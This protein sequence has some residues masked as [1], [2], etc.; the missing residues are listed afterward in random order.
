MNSR[1]KFIRT[2]ALL[3]GAAYFYP[4][5]DLKSESLENT[6]SGDTEDYWNLVRAQ[7]P[8]KSNKTFLNNGTMGPSPYPVLQAVIEEMNEIEGSAR[9]GGNDSRAVQDLARLISC[10][11]DEISL[12]HNVTEGINIVAF[13]L[14]LQ[15][16]D[17]V[18][19]T[20]H[21]HVGNA[22]P[23]LSRAKQ[24]GIVV[25]AVQPGKDAAT[26]LQNILEAISKKTK[27]LAIPHMPCTIGQ[28]FP[29]QEICKLAREN[30]IYT[31]IDGAHPPGMM[32]V[33]VKAMGCDFYVSCVHKWLMGPKGTAF[34]Y[35]SDEKRE[36]LS[37]RFGGAGVDTGWDMLANPPAMEE[38]V[39]TGH[40]YYYG[41]QNAA[42]YLGISKAIEFHEQIGVVN[43]ENRV[44]FLSEYLR[45]KL[46]NLSAD[47]EILTPEEKKSRAAVT[48][49][50]MKDKEMSDLHKFLNE[51]KITT[52]YVAENNINCLR[53]S[54]HIYNNTTDLDKLVEGIQ[55]FL[56]K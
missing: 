31:M 14:P 19:L 8:L 2:G 32:K 42:L 44:N 51:E 43:I 18:I 17:E 1:R 24:D 3:S 48:A 35:V 21:E 20:T 16:G 36:I 5:H 15:K 49:F 22:G 39:K 45:E 38:F 46:K 11:Q 37:A 27:V 56:K 28:V 4:F 13:G 40:K 10:H 50:K 41:T 54:N 53:V 55:K 23:W 12:T 9:Y 25:K 34:V 29:V 52:R 47:I 26:T 6:Q 33:D 30:N 7:F